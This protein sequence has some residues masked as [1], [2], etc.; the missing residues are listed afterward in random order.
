[1]GLYVQRR[2]KLK[3]EKWLRLTTT[4][5]HKNLLK[6]FL[7]Q[8]HQMQLIIVLTPSAQLLPLTNFPLTQLKTKGT[9]T[10]QDIS[11]KRL[12]FY[13]ETTQAIP[14]IETLFYQQINFRCVFHKEKPR[15]SSKGKML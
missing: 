14:L 7:D 4:E 11:E 1:M 3:P 9:Y 15:T 10:K 12:N 13:K 8:E 6:Q 2:L 5:E